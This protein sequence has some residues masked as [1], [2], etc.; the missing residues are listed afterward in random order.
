MY[1]N[2]TAVMLSIFTILKLWHSKRGKFRN[3]SRGLWSYFVFCDALLGD[4]GTKSHFRPPPGFLVE[5]C[6][7][8]DRK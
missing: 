8:P 3:G 1:T 7:Q 4:F 5:I 2:I 6:F